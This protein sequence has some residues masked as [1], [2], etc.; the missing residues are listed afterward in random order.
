MEYETTLG[1]LIV[2][3]FIHIGSSQSVCYFLFDWN[4]TFTVRRIQYFY[5][6]MCADKLSFRVNNL[7]GIYLR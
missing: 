4:F 1:E 6:F 5:F 7:L 3:L 2:I